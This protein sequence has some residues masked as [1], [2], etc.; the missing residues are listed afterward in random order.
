VAGAVSCSR[1]SFSRAEA[2]VTPS[3]TLPTR[4]RVSSGGCGAIVPQGRQRAPVTRASRNA[5]FTLPREARGGSG[6]GWRSGPTRM[7]FGG[8]GRVLQSELFSRA[9]AGVTPSPTLPTRGRVRPGALGAMVPQGRQ[10]VPGSDPLPNPPRKGEG[11][12]SVAVGR[13]CP[14]QREAGTRLRARVR[15]RSPSPAKRG[16]GARATAAAPPTP[17]ARGRPRSGRRRTG[18]TPPASRQAP[19][20]SRWCRTPGSG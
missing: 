5:P 10:R 17:P 15:P 2:G 18:A 19:V 1:D 13:W 12:R 20:P 3:P 6:R 9:E 8:W 7:T 16:E 11:V 14:R 4:G